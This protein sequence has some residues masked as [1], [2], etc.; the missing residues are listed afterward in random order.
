MNTY[1]VAL[2]NGKITK[3]KGSRSTELASPLT[4]LLDRRIYH[5]DAEDVSAAVSAAQ[6]AYSSWSKTDGAARRKVIEALAQTIENRAEAIAAA[7]NSEVGTPEKIALAVQAGLPVNV[8]RGFAHDLDLA[9]TD[10]TIAHSTIQYRPLGVVA[11]ITPWNYPLHQA[12][13]KI[14]AALA[15]GCTLVLKPSD[16]T[17]K[18][19]ALIMEMLAETTPPGTVNIVPGDAT[20]GAELIAHAGINAVSFTGSVKGGRSVAQA[21]AKALKPC[22][23]E[24]GGK[25]A[26]ILLDD[27]TPAVAL[28][29]IV[30]SGFLNSGQTCTALTR[31]LVPNTMLDEATAQIGN[32]ADKMTHRLGPMISQEQYDRVQGFIARAQQDD[33]VTLV[34]GGVGHPDGREDGYYVRPTVFISRDPKAEIVQQEVFGPVLVIMGYDNDDDLIALANGTDYGLAAAVWGSDTTRIKEITGRLLAGQIDVNGALFNP[35]APFGGFNCSGSGREMGLH[36]IREFQRP[37]SIQQKN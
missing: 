34:T 2:V 6:R 31:I 11:A 24:L 26:G 19:N 36:G 10:E 35:R 20:T 15:A 18:T 7:I 5:G 28:K 37:V 29:A 9:L 17:P 21:A 23:L 33:A 22:F 27:A 3:L 30:N 25:S 4:G 32:L 13:A 8:L 12:M 14:G 1:S 16:L